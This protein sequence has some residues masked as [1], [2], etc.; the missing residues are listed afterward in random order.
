MQLA[1]SAVTSWCDSRGFAFSVSKTKTVLFRRDKRDRR[2]A[3]YPALTLYDLPIPTVLQV[4]FLG[5]LLDARLTYF[6]HILDLKIKCR[7]PL[8]LLRGLTSTSWGADRRVL[9]R[10]LIVLVRSRLDYGSAIYGQTSSRYLR[11]LDPV[12]NEGLRI[13]TGAFRSS[14]AVSLEVEAG[15]MPLSLRREQLMCSLYLRLQIPNPSA[16]TPLIDEV[17][18][19]PAH[20]PFAEVVTSIF[21]YLRLPLRAVLQFDYNTAFPYWIYP[22]PMVCLRLA[23][24]LKSRDHP[25]LLKASFLSHLPFHANSVQIYTDGSLREGLVGSSAVFPDIQ[26]SHTLP[27]CSSIFTAELVAIV[28]ALYRIGTLTT[29]NS[30]TIFSDSRSALLALQSRPTRHPLIS[31]IQRFLC[32]L[33]TRRKQV[34]FCWVPSHVG[35][36]GNELADRAAFHAA[37]HV[38]HCRLYLPLDIRLGLLPASDFYSRLKLGFL[39]CWQ[40]FWSLDVHGA[41][42]RSVK[43]L[44]GNWPSSYSESRHREVIL[45]RLRIGHTNVTHSYLMAGENPPVCPFCSSMTPLSIHHIFVDCEALTASRDRFFPNLS[46]VPLRSRFSYLLSDSPTFCS[47]A[48]FAFLRDLAL[49]YRI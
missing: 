37:S 8:D 6:P 24:F 33:H 16:L 2:G 28:L 49:T 14:P 9:L 12:Q 29:Q 47:D 7:R 44:L 13:A 35:I 46:S 3:L 45:S 32:M 38:V 5:L 26:V 36:P 11:L 18:H 4:R 10:L 48:V 41:K 17:S 40:E 20:W 27:S 42:L 39:R 22:P 34:S 15:V 31:I 30:F 19:S 1:V 21:T 23:S 43:P 25:S